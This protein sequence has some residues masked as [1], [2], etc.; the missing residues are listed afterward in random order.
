MTEQG[1]D[2]KFLRSYALRLTSVCL[3][4]TG[5][6][7]PLFMFVE[8]SH[9]HSSHQAPAINLEMWSFTVVVLLCHLLLSGS[10]I[11][12]VILRHMHAMRHIIGAYPINV[13]FLVYTCQQLFEFFFMRVAK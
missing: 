13:V 10:R 11:L 8:V 4:K 3:F 6:G 5:W 12:Y 7:V 2:S 9:S 1:Q